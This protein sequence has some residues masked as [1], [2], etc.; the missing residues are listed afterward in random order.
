M[1]VDDLRIKFSFFDHLKTK[2]LIRVCG[3]EGVFCLLYLW[4]YAGMNCQKGHLKD[5]TPDDIEDAACWTGDNGVLYG[6]LNGSF[7]D[8]L[9]GEHYLHDWER[10][11]GYIFYAE[12]R[13]DNARKAGLASGESR[14]KGIKTDNRTGSSTGCSTGSPTPSPSPLPSPTPLPIPK[15][16]DKSKLEPYISFIKELFPDTSKTQLEKQAEVLEKIVRIDKCSFDWLQRVL[17][18]ARRDERD[19]FN[20]SSNF[21]SC[22]PLRIRNPAGD[23]MKWEKMA[24][25]YKKVKGIKAKVSR[26]V[27]ALTVGTSATPREHLDRT[28]RRETSVSRTQ[29]QRTTK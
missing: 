13:S 7:I 16:S 4:K 15:S 20:W 1:A 5:M 12:E 6:V 9:N 26:P 25:D 21:L 8:L 22:A 19:R 27:H 14:K 29:R 2:R 28:G 17:R 3:F 10:H 11:Q 23:T 24:A 18:W